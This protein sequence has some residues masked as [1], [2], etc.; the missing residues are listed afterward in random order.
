MSLIPAIIKGF[1]ALRPDLER[2]KGLIKKGSLDLRKFA[3]ATAEDSQSLMQKWAIENGIAA[4]AV[5]FLTH[6]AGRVILEKRSNDWAGLI[7]D[8]AWDKG[9]CPVCGS[10][11]MMARVDDGIA[12]R[13]LHCSQCSHE[14]T[15]SR[16]I[17]PSC[18]NRN[19]NTMDYFF[20]E[21]NEQE[22]A[23]SCTQ[24]KHYLITLNKVSDLVE[25][26]GEISA[27]SL[28]H[29]DV[30]MQGKGYAPMVATE[31]NILS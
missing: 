26:N 25:F 27:L 2:L 3:E 24:C 29:M 4:Q 6:M 5:T 8:F 15:F 31:W 10:A 20:I 16:V 18:N 9:Y 21:G 30:L 14:W 22:S 23:F 7:K 19:Q 17:C 11:P 28:V 12:K 1:P 13:W